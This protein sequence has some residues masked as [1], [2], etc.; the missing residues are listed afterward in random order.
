MF[1][2]NLKFTVEGHTTDFFSNRK[3]TFRNKNIVLLF[4][5]RLNLLILWDVSEKRERT[6][7]D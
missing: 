4:Q 3:K 1:D 2:L 6:V 7:D 5:L